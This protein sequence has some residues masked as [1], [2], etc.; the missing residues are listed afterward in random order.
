MEISLE[1]RPRMRKLVVTSVVLFVL[2][3][4][5]AAQESAPAF[6]VF[7]GYSFLNPEGS[8]FN[9]NGWEAAGTAYLN[10]WFGATADFSGHYASESGVDTSTYSFLFGPTVA[11]RTPKLTPYAHILLGANRARVSTSI[12]GASLSVTDTA[13]AGA[14]GGGVDWHVGNS[15]SVRLAQADYLITRFNDNRQDNFRFSAGLVLRLGSK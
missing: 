14:L 10:N 11:Y 1:E 9:A 2:V 5:G 8:G 3:T 13:F 15:W 7:G 12:F 4:L 6:D